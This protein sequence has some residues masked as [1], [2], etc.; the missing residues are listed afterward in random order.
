MKRQI[1]RMILAVAVCMS[2]C[3]LR[4][5]I[6]Y[7]SRITGNESKL[8]VDRYGMDEPV[9]VSNGYLFVESEYIPAPYHVQRVGQAIAVN[10]TLVS[11]L[12]RGDPPFGENARVSGITED[13][14]KKGRIFFAALLTDY[15]QAHEVVFLYK[16]EY[17]KNYE[18]MPLSEYKMSLRV[19]IVGRFDGRAFPHLL[20]DAMTNQ[21]NASVI[22][23]ITQ[24]PMRRCLTGEHVQTIIEKAKRD[25]QL[26]ERIRTETGFALEPVAGE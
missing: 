18:P 6:D 9:V 16:S 13:M 19:P 1:K 12:F 21:P 7:G 10:G 25:P 17:Q 8:Y 26:L 15:L 22:S 5:E 14:L 2:A 24:G 3:V 4:A 11:C 23:A 20:N